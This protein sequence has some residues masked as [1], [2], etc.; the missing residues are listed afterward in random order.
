MEKA[1]SKSS[2]LFQKESILKKTLRN[3][4]NASRFR[5]KLPLKPHFDP[6]VELDKGNEILIEIENNEKPK[7]P[8]IKELRKDLLY[9][10]QYYLDEPPNINPNNSFVSFNEIHRKQPL[11]FPDLNYV[12]KKELQLI[13]EKKKKEE[14]MTALEKFFNEMKR[15]SQH[16]RASIS[17]MKA[18]TN[19]RELDQVRKEL[20]H[21]ESQKKLYDN[22][23]DKINNSSNEILFEKYQRNHKKYLF[24]HEFNNEIVY[25]Y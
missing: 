20:T 8:I 11:L 25:L 17:I 1:R 15:D 3:A 6:P 18:I 4:T 23:M 7:P 9:I 21:N 16:S 13:E 14:S 2:H 12:S 24:F 19:F 22:A 5:I 10:P